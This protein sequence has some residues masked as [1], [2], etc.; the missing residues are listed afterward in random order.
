M[1]IVE[2]IFAVAGVGNIGLL[3]AIFF[4]LGKGAAKFEGFSARLVD[5]VS[6]L[7]RIE[8]IFITR[9]AN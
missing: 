6:R 7:E 2:A 5:L 1:S 4:R 8:E 9:R 3:T